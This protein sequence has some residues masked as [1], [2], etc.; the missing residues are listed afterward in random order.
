M[1]RVFDTEF[2]GLKHASCGIIFEAAFM[3]LDENRKEMNS[4]YWEIKYN[5][6]E[7]DGRLWKPILDHMNQNGFLDK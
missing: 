5:I 6:Y 4:Y 3:L 2:I 7:H 1:I